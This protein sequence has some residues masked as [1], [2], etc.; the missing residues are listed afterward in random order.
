MKFLAI[1]FTAV[2]PLTLCAVASADSQCKTFLNQI[3]SIGF[4]NCQVNGQA[5]ENYLKIT[6]RK[7]VSWSDGQSSGQEMRYVFFLY[8]NKEIVRGLGSVEID[9][10]PGSDTNSVSCTDSQLK[11]AKSGLI[12]GS[13]GIY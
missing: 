3:A 5:S 9:S 10:I 12:K 13:V 11:F 4:Q 2:F 6:P 7:G 8:N 1:S